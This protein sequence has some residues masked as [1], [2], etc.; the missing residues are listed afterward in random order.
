MFLQGILQMQETAV[1]VLLHRTIVLS[2]LVDVMEEDELINY[3][4][5]L[6]GIA[7]DSINANFAADQPSV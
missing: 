2:Q 1:P 3:K 7:T 6:L 4:E 5:P